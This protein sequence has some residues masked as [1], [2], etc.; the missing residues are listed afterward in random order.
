MA[1]SIND[2]YD[3][4][5][6]EVVDQ[7]QNQDEPIQEPEPPKNDDDDS[8]M[9]D[10]L[11]TKGISDPNKIKF[12]D[13]NHNI[14][15]R[16]WNDLTREEQINILNTPLEQPSQN[17]NN[18]ENQLTEEEIQ[19]INLIRQNNQ[20]PQ[21]YLD[22]L[23]TPQEPVYK[24]DDLSDDE[25]YL[26]DFESRVGELS[27]EQ[28]AQV[29]AS[30][31]QDEDL[32]KKQVEGIRKEYKEREDYQQNQEKMELEQQQQEAYNQYQDAV[33]NAID[34]F[35]SIGNLDLNFDDSDKNELAEFML[36]QDEQ[37]SNYFYKALQDPET[38]VK[39]AW[40]ILNGDE[41]FNNISDY[42]INQIKTVSENQYK[43]GYEEG[44]KGVNPTR[45]NVV[46]D[47]SKNKSSRNYTSINDLYDED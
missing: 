33:I 22:S 36:N 45:P 44:K 38:L 3:D 35:N 27:D 10:F 2:L 39:A 5:D 24:I 11:R 34:S 43:K 28:A 29:L 7:P 30:A 25:L 31:K 40:F 1:I 26:I 6:L 32:Y 41:A 12:E 13:E 23:Q 14:I 47:N 20:T 18:N 8:F 46:I 37:G 16:S 15:E 21:Q 4:D 9:T 42:F 19:F 17:V